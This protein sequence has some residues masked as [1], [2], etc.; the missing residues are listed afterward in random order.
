MRVRLSETSL[1][2]FIFDLEK[3]LYHEVICIL[4]TIRINDALKI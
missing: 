4:A 1:I 2:L 3:K